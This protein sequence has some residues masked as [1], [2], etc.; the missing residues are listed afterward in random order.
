MPVLHLMDEFN[1]DL[2]EP[3]K[4]SLMEKGSNVGFSNI[5]YLDIAPFVGLDPLWNLSDAPLFLLR[6]SRI[7]TALFR[8]IVM[9]M[10]VLLTQYG[11]FENHT[12]EEAR[13]RFLA[14][15]FNRLVAP[16]GS[17]IRN[18]PESLMNGRITTR[19]KIVYHFKTFGIL[20]VVF[21]EA[22]LKIGSTEDRLN[23]I[24][25]VIAE[26]AACDWN[27]LRFDVSIPIYSILCDG[28][29]FQFFT[30]D[31]ST[32]PYKFS[33]GIV[34]GSRFRVS[35]GLSLV[36]F[37]SEPT[38]RSF[39][40]S[41]RPICE[42]VFNLLLVGYIASLKMF[43]DRSA[44]RRKS[45]DGWGKA[46]KFAEEALEKS[47]DAEALRRDDLT[48]DADAATETAFK[49]LKLST[50]VVPI[51]EDYINPPLMNGWSDDEVAKV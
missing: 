2:E 48:V 9:D 28:S 21:V 38:A 4:A 30:F 50:D 8:D 41:L 46:L 47:L 31:G 17:S 40:H 42:T 18:T 13:S 44:S 33:M 12:T 49:T 43:R 45:L 36:D 15:I 20:T 19:G 23:A 25:Q 10:D 32:K 51:A 6:R 16:F 1:F 26:C 35:A 24:A 39:I 5:K 37:T 14:P 29:S 7:P 22:K 11:N 3:V 27:N 34:P